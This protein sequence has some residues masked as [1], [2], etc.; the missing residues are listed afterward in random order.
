MFEQLFKEKQFVE[1]KDLETA[2]IIS[3]TK[4][5]QAREDGF[6]QCIRV[7]KKVFYLQEHLADYFA[8]ATIAQN[9][10]KAAK[11][12]AAPQGA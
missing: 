6:L 5:W 12:A 8:K 9:E 4:Q 10:K 7:G 11:K 1:P 2:G 3:K